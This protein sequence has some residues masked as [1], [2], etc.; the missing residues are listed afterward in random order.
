[1]KFV[2]ELKL[3]KNC[4]QSC[5]SKKKKSKNKIGLV[6]MTFGLVRASY[7]YL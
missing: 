1:M 3:Q 6:K 4:N 2:G 5:S 7:S